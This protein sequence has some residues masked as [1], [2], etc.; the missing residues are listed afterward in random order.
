MLN[1]QAQLRIEERRRRQSNA[2]AVEEKQMRKMQEKEDILRQQEVELAEQRRAEA[3]FM[4][5]VLRRQEWAVYQ[6]W[7]KKKSHQ[8]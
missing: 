8:V 3:Y 2:R 4:N 5:E 6:Q 7:E 1:G